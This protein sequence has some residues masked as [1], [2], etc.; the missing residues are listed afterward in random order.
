MA[1][2]KNL[3]NNLSAFGNTTSRWLSN[4]RLMQKLV[5]DPSIGSTFANIS[6]RLGNAASLASPLTKNSNSAISISNG[7]DFATAFGRLGLGGDLAAVFDA[8]SSFAKIP[9]RFSS[10]D[11]FNSALSQLIPR[12]M[13]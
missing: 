12:S 5:T 1:N 11:D 13:R 7:G 9:A 2:L 6:R 4:P 10:E 3:F 8:L